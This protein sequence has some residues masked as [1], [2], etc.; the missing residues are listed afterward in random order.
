MSFI[1]NFFENIRP[2]TLI[3]A[4]KQGVVV[5]GINDETLSKDS[6]GELR[7]KTAVFIDGEANSPSLLRDQIFSGVKNNL[8][9][10]QWKDVDREFEL[11]EDSV[12][13]SLFP[14]VKSDIHIMFDLADRNHL[15]Q[16]DSERTPYLSNFK[17]ILVPGR[18]MQRRLLQDKRLKLNP[19]S[20]VAVGS[21]RIAYLQ[22]LSSTKKTEPHTMDKP[23][24]FF[25]P[26]HSNWLDSSGRPM[27]SEASMTPFFNTL[28]DH[29]NFDVAV[30]PRNKPNKRPITEQLLNADVVITDYTSVI[31]EAWALGKPV[32]FPRWLLGEKIF[33]K[34][35]DSAEAY[36]YENNLG[37]HAS[38]LNQL[39]DFIKN[40]QSIGLG[41]GVETF[42]DDYLGNHKSS[43]PSILIANVIDRLADIEFITQEQQQREA[44]ERAIHDKNWTLAE[45]LLTIA[46]ASDPENPELH[47]KLAATYQAQKKWWQV[48]KSLK[49]TLYY[50]PEKSD[51]HFKLGI[52]EQ[53]MLRF[54][55]AASAYQTCIDL[56]PEKATADRYYKLGYCYEN[57]DEQSSETNRLKNYA[58]RK[59]CE[60]DK[61][62]EASRFGIGVFHT[63][64][65]R[66][67]NAR[68]E[69]LLK[70]VERPL[71][72]DLFYKLG[73]SFDRCYRW[74]EARK[75]YEVAVSLEPTRAA[76]HYRL[77]FV[78]ERTENYA[79]AAEA[80]KFAISLSQE[81][82]TTWN[83]RVA[84]C[85]E[86]SGK[87]SEACDEYLKLQTSDTAL[88]DSSSR[89]S[90]K[91]SLLKAKYL[92]QVLSEGPENANLWK[93]YSQSLETNRNYHD[94]MIAIDKAIVLSDRAELTQLFTKRVNLANKS[95]ERELIERRLQQD[96]TQPA[97]WLHYS[98]IFEEAGDFHE[99]AKCVKQAIWRSN[100]HKPDLEFRLGHLLS[101][102]DLPEEACAAFR[103]YSL[104]QRPHGAYEDKFLTDATLNF[105]ATYREFFD[106]L[107]I[108]EDTILYEVHNGSAMACNP[109]AI[110]EHLLQN[111]EFTN[112]KH[113]WIVND[114]ENVPEKYRALNNV[115]FAKRGST[116][117]L[118][119]LATCKYLICNGT[120]AEYFVRKDGQRYL[121]TWHGTPLKTLGKD[122]LTPPF[123]RTNTA[124]N[125]L[126][127][128]HLIFPNEHTR[129]TQ[130]EGHSIDKIV[131]ANCL[132]SGYPRNDQL[133]NI[134]HSKNANIRQGLG[135]PDTK[136]VVLFAP[137]YRG[138]W[139]SP[140]LE[141]EY[142]IEQ[143]KKMIDPSYVLLFRGHHL[144]EK[145]LLALDLPVKV[146]PQAIDTNS[147]LPIVDILISDYSSIIMDYLVLERPIVHYIPDWD[148]YKTTRGLYFERKDLPWHQCDTAEAVKVAVINAIENPHSFI[149]EKQ[150][151]FAEQYCKAEDGN[152]TR[153]VIDFFF[154]TSPEQQA[155]PKGKRAIIRTALGTINGVASSAIS[156][157]N[158]LVSQDY[159][160]TLLL[161][162]V[163][164]K[165]EEAGFDI[166]RKLEESVN[167]VFRTG[168]SSM[169][170]EQ[171]WI[172]DKFNAENSF[173]SP[174]MEQIFNTSARQE[175]Y[176]MLGTSEFDLSLEHQG[177]HPFWVG[178]MAN[179]N[180]TDHA[181]Y[182]H[183]DMVEESKQ[184]L[185]NLKRT[186][187]LYKNYET[188][189]NVSN[190][191][192]AINKENFK[193]IF[194]ELIENFCQVRNGLDAERIV[195]LAS[196]PSDDPDI[197]QFNN[198]VR[199]KLI[200][201]ARMWPEKNQV[202]LIEMVRVLLDKGQHVS[203]YVLG[204]GPLLSVLEAKIAELG[205]NDHVFLLGVKR[206]PFQFL[207]SADC[208]VLSSDY[209]GQGIVLLEAMSLGVPCVSTNIPGPDNVLENGL[210]LLTELSPEAL[211][212]AV[213][214]IKKGEFKPKKFDAKAYNTDALNEFLS[215]V[216]KNNPQQIDVSS[217]A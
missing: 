74:T 62:L 138:S 59:A 216:A 167:V 208:H 89:Y 196:A 147:L 93:R 187:Q 170:L 131:T 142:L 123:A 165:K 128:T 111:P 180:A 55:E 204:T 45:T 41:E 110:F 5:N 70:I 30:D 185:P 19:S 69:F 164:L 210:G 12:S 181:I 64:V 60:L 38:S 177:Y 4:I 17:K 8:S 98:D 188:F 96:C 67:E 43:N 36:I 212:N 86:M 13:I 18:W 168:R 200:N 146:A 100:E 21:P 163:E 79:D 109:L 143:L 31:Y 119:L 144:V 91:I 207:K 78:C 23:N 33:D 37:H 97:D 205:L 193:P 47:E 198:D 49:S 94:A 71:D 121:N 135:I 201:I 173:Y 183:N 133:I 190:S 68:K 99:A 122:M 134:D 24:V 197:E 158:N 76:W 85:L 157:A 114:L 11:D 53:H 154:N 57:S 39:C 108:L 217:V 213:I 145:Q 120:F 199:F 42:L 34:A 166:I 151:E 26:L 149:N 3:S 90:R 174:A 153:R 20:I 178:I 136:P 155:R 184:R 206:N 159:D 195:E 102:S 7:P 16:V 2:D 115:F 156:L 104:I 15:R 191:S 75:Y 118:R 46:T 54:A 129:Y 28:K 1:K 189:I 215:A 107:P 175:C 172:F 65:G 125:F 82:R 152:A 141:A 137:T 127:A 32:I 214:A 140:A 73:M 9:S 139:N 150:S 48:V 72:A 103:N 126:H 169:S 88:R 203:L 58:Y 113:F 202:R 27:S 22:K 101:L 50:Y 179:I 84:F 161:D 29:C 40:W 112:F 6:A 211:A 52:A 186:F 25:A 116:L 56:A 66:W 10:T 182:L 87:Y 160:V 117:Y 192:M 209:E 148:D 176:R 162:S 106:V 61:S 14:N 80:Y 171:Q 194:P 95:A 63:S 44:I 132:I 83:Y 35:P 81:P 77:G 105:H 124:R 92:N 51:L 130:I